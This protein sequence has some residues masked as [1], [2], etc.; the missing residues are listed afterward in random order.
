MKHIVTN[1]EQEFGGFTELI[2]GQDTSGG[3][4]MGTRSRVLTIHNNPF[5]AP[6][7]GDLKV[8]IQDRTEINGHVQGAKLTWFSY[9][10]LEQLYVSIGT[11]LGK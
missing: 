11:I 7:S 10:D 1:D 9:T 5:Y 6:K 2:E 8:C 4:V 3:P